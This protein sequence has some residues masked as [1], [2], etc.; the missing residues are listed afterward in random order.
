MR[1]AAPRHRPERKEEP[2][3][4]RDLTASRSNL[5]GL[6]I[7]LALL[8]HSLPWASAMAPAH[9]NTWHFLH[10]WRRSLSPHDG[11][12]LLRL[13]PPRYYVPPDCESY[14]GSCPPN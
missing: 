12:S 13:R 7:A 9:H 14:K 2:T 5:P 6:S 1:S 11:D 4:A 3:A 10:A 8:D